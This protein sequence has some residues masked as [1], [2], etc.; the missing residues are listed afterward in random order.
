MKR[1]KDC[2]NFDKWDEPQIIDNL[3]VY[4]GCSVDYEY[5]YTWPNRVCQHPEAFVERDDV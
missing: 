1:C 5:L 4:G 2:I 3:H